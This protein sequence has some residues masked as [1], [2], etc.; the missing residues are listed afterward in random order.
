MKVS[1][2]LPKKI[3]DANSETVGEIAKKNGL[4]YCR[5]LKLVNVLVDEGKAIR[6]WKKSGTRLVPAYKVK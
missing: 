6:V 3:I 1:E 2:M 4:N 5:A